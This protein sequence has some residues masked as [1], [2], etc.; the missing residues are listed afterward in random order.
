MTTGSPPDV[1]S[2]MFENCVIINCHYDIDEYGKANNY[3]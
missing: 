3:Y 1:V 2:I